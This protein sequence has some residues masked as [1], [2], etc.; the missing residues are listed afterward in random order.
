MTLTVSYYGSN[1][2]RLYCFSYAEKI[3]HIEGNLKTVY[4][5]HIRSNSRHS[6]FWYD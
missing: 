6:C 3:T 5:W 4:Y 1:K 2:N